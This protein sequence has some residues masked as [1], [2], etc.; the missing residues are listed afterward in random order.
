[1][2]ERFRPYVEREDC[3][4]CGAVLGPCTNWPWHYEEEDCRAIRAPKEDT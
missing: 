3:G 2:S 1:M 4:G